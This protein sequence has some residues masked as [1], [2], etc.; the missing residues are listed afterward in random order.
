MPALLPSIRLPSTRF[1]LPWRSTIEP[2]VLRRVLNRTTLSE[3][4]TVVAGAGD[5][6]EHALGALVLERVVV[7]LGVVADHGDPVRAAGELYDVAG[8]P[9]VVGAGRD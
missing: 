3:D 1:R 8:E 6:Q 7:D 5:L 4:L 2:R 9:D